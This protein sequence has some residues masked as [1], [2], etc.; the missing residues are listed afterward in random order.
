[1]TLPELLRMNRMIPL[2]LCPSPTGFNTTLA[3][4]VA[5]LFP[6]GNQ[7]PFS[8]PDVKNLKICAPSPDWKEDAADQMPAWSTVFA[9]VSA[10]L[11]N[12]GTGGRKCFASL[13]LVPVP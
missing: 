8:Y 13:Y 2:S 11:Y 7:P 1:M 9:V 5:K 6:L 3:T 12:Q 4:A 10:T